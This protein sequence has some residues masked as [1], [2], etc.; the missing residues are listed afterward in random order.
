M[1]KYDNY[2]GVTRDPA[3]DGGDT[4]DWNPCDHAGGLDDVEWSV[5]YAD[6]TGRLHAEVTALVWAVD[7]PPHDE[8]GN[9]TDGS[10]YVIPA[11]LIGAT[12]CYV[13]GCHW[14]WEHASDTILE[15]CPAGTSLE[16][17]QMGA[18][19]L[20]DGPMQGAACL[21]VENRESWLPGRP[22]FVVDDADPKHP[23]VYLRYERQEDGAAPYISE[24]IPFAP[25][26]DPGG[27]ILAYVERQGWDKVSP[28]DAEDAAPSE[29]DRLIEQIVAAE[30]ESFLVQAGADPQEFRL[31]LRDILLDDYER[32]RLTVEQL[33]AIAR[34]HGVF[35]GDEKSAECD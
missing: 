26:G 33:K 25:G 31:R 12:T 10:P 15:H 2:G 29:R 23:V 13:A 21:L 24:A 32:E 7:V 8:E 5:V 19:N 28:I 14:D 34:E 17:A 9:T 16:A 18:R 30:V 1:G 4:Y 11:D 35:V 6:P 3:L 22:E 20:C 27:A